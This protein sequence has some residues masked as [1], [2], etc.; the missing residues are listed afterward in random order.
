MLHALHLQVGV[1]I[2]AEAKDLLQPGP[3]DTVSSDLSVHDFRQ[4]S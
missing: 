3:Q 4:P 1:M 2:Q